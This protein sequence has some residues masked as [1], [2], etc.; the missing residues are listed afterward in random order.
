MWMVFKSG[1]PKKY[2]FKNTQVH[3]EVCEW[4]GAVVSKPVQ[5]SDAEMSIKTAR[6]VM[7]HAMHNW[8]CTE[9][10]NANANM[11]KDISEV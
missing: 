11:L 4:P 1:I 9:T 10:D 6:T 7:Q 2:V 3:V 5:T 8:W